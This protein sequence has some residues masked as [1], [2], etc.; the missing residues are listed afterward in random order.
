MDTM[1]KRKLLIYRLLDL[2]NKAHHET[3]DTIIAKAFINSRFEIEQLSLEDIAQKHYISQSSLSR[4]IKK[5]G[6]DNYNSFKIALT[7]SNYSLENTHQLKDNYKSLSTQQIQSQ[8]Y[9]NIMKAIENAH[10]IDLV[11][12]NQMIQIL[13]NYPSIIL[14]GS[15]LSMAICH[16]LQLLL[17][18]IKKNVFT[19]FDLTYQQEIIESVDPSTLIICISLEERWFSTQ[20]NIEAIFST[21]AFT[22]LWT[23]DS[24]HINKQDFDKVF[25]FG[26]S[27]DN[28][29]GY[30]ELMYFIMLL[31][32]FIQNE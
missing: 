31:Y 3:S 8:V 19:I 7:I 23:L 28:N 1:Q 14:L 17:L 24:N 16:I 26:D 25:L 29:Y 21:E 11:Q 2:V 22:M 20:E 15:E 6:F 13:K 4:F 10:Q 12:L 32:R 18:T 5:M 27:V 9:S 30:H